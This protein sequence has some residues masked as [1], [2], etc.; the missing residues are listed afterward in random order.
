MSAGIGELANIYADD[1]QY[2]LSIQLQKQCIELEKGLV[3]PS[4]PYHIAS[5]VNLAS[6]FLEKKDFESALQTI[7]TVLILQQKPVIFL[8]SKELKS[9]FYKL[10]F[11]KR[12]VKSWTHFG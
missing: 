7:D 1:G 6:V 12:Q 5:Y 9:V 8:I 10:R 3:N 4:H 2:D 11:M